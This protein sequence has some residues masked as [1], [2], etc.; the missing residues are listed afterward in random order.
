MILFITT[1]LL[2]FCK[3]F[4]VSS[5]PHLTFTVWPD[6]IQTS[7]CSHLSLSFRFLL[8]HVVHVS[9]PQP[10]IK[11]LYEIWI[12][13]I[14]GLL[15]VQRSET[16]KSTFFCPRKWLKE[17]QKENKVKYEDPPVIHQL[18]IQN[19]TFFMTDVSSKEKEKS[20]KII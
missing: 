3:R 18:Q 14:A 13:D 8:V 7:D 4:T 10:P 15:S 12:L 20:Y 17:S 5:H 9:N 1:V 11:A 2:L 16:I 19:K 6:I